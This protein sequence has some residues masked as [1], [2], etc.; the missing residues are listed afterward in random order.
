MANHAVSFFIYTTIYRNDNFGDISFE[1]VKTNEKLVIKTKADKDTILQLMISRYPLNAAKSWIEANEKEIAEWYRKGFG[2]K[3]TLQ[4][5]L[6]IG[7]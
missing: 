5:G 2:R 4:N 3:I 1:D 6:T 7:I